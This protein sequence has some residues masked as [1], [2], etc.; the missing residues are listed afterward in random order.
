MKI[1]ETVF[2]EVFEK[3]RNTVY[4]VVFNYVRNVEDTADL[5]QE[6]FL[7]L[8]CSGN[9]YESE[10]HLK[11]WL[12]RVSVNLCKN[13]LRSK[14]R[15]SALSLSEEIPAA[16]QEKPDELFAVVL[17]LPEKYRVPLHLYYYEEYSIR[18]IAEVT[19]T[20]EATVK[21]RLKR[22]REKL[23]KALRKEDWI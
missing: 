13:F 4:S 16:E 1:T 14:S 18:Q 7:K 19:D 17:T 23:G 20:P 5:Q 10:E 9:D 11:A 2:P 15:M 21:I 8:L 3:Y 22:G 6:V 12:I